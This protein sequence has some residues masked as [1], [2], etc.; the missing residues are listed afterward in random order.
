LHDVRVRGRLADDGAWKSLSSPTSGAP[1]HPQRQ[2]YTG[3]LEKGIMSS[4]SQK[5][6]R[7]KR[8]RKCFSGTSSSPTPFLRNVS[9]QR[10]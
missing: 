6:E 9:T 7:E 10:K 3:W 4:S 8:C 2:R 1:S 5:M